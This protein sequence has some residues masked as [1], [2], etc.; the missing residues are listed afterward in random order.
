MCYNVL[1]NNKRSYLHLH[2]CNFHFKNTRWGL[3]ETP[4]CILSIRFEIG[5][6]VKKYR[7]VKGRIKILVN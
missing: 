1:V 4:P 6:E 5:V 3:F 7:Y 2:I